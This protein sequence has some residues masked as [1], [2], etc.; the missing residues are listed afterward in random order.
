MNV[1]LKKSKLKI[2]QVTTAYKRYLLEEIRKENRIS[3]IKGARGVG[4]TTLLLQY[5]KL[6]I[7]KSKSVLYVSLD[8]LFFTENNLYN[9]AE[10]FYKDNGD[11]LLLDEVHKYPNC[12]KIVS[13]GTCNPL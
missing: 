2:S 4:K 5:A 9:L 1:L 3:I 10:E 12:F 7:K 8:D 11:Y 13:S 6:K